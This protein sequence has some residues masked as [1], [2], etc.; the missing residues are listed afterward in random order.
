MT[1]SN[2]ATHLV[3]AAEIIVGKQESLVGAN[4]PQ[5]ECLEVMKGKVCEVIEN[6]FKNAK[7]PLEGILILTELFGGTP[8]NATL[9]QIQMMDCRIEVLTGV[10]LPL[11]I[12]ALVNRHKLGL[13]DLAEKVLADGIKGIQDARAILSL[14]IKPE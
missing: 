12:S 5:N 6:C 13:K 14:R 4:L 3:E 2:V 11:L 9:A 7:E 10:N 1:H 8:T